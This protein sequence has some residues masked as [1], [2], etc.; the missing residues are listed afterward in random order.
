MSV[1]L[2][3]EYLPVDFFSVNL[4][5]GFVLSSDELPMTPSYHNMNYLKNSDVQLSSKINSVGNV[6][7]SLSVYQ[8]EQMLVDYVAGRCCGICVCFIED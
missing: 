2:R 6:M 7:I 8:Y 4:Q 3:G 1:Y 5:Q